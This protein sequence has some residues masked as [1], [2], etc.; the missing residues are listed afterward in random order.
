M[1]DYPIPPWLSQGGQP[2]AEAY[3]KGTQ[4]GMQQ[5][6]LQQRLAQANAQHQ[7]QM[8]VEQQRLAQQ[9]QMAQ[10]EWQAKTAIAER[11]AQ[12][13][14]TQL[15]MTRAYHE[16]QLGLQQRKLEEQNQL[17][18]LKI[19]DAAN[20]AQAQGMYEQE[21]QQLMAQGGDMTP[22]QAYQQ[23]A[24]KWGPKMGLPSGAY[25]AAFRGTPGD[26][27]DLGQVSSPAG[28][29][30]VHFMKTGRYNV[31]PLNIPTDLT[32]QQAQP[33]PAKGMIIFNNK[34]YRIPDVTKQLRT[35]LQKLEDVQEKDREGHMADMMSR[36]KQKMD[37]TAKMALDNYNSRA[38]KIQDLSRQI[39]KMEN[40]T[41]ATG[42]NRFE[43]DI[44]GKEDE[45]DT[46]YED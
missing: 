43:P 36:T 13:E 5:S 30:D 39:E 22:Q 33:G 16:A 25:S 15:E 17:W 7:Q 31:S 19:D 6:E 18:Q 44:S 11:N 3:Q 29:P 9:A 10:M 23:A 20:K 24:L 40:Q 2:Y 32:Q 38:R 37:A 27:P 14:E 28:F 26:V 46:S 12:R 42:T 21:A 34:V 41:P 45:E 8:Q 1:A 35:Q 4:L